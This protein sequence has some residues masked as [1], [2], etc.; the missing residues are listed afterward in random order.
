MKI[1]IMNRH[2][3]AMARKYKCVFVCVCVCARVRVCARAQVCVCVCVC[4]YIHTI[5]ER[6]TW[7]LGDKGFRL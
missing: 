7:V 4:T 1:N 3:L 6:S 2:P 5:T